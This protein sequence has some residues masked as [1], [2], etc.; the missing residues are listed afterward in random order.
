MQG[1]PKCTEA[2]VR[3]AIQFR[4]VPLGGFQ[5]FIVVGNWLAKMLAEIAW[6]FG[7]TEELKS[8]Y[9]VLMFRSGPVKRLS[10]FATLALAPTPRGK[11][12]LHQPFIQIRVSCETALNNFRLVQ[13]GIQ[14][15]SQLAP[16]RLKHIGQGTLLIV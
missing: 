8:G 11:N 4:F 2:S 9:S 14:V 16:Q 15:A 3:S 6:Q 7:I 13:F 5:F 12:V 1:F 10:L